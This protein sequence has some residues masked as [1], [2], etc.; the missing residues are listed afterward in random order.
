MHTET[1]FHADGEVR[2]VKPATTELEPGQGENY[3][4]IDILLAPEE[5]G[6]ETES[7]PF[8]IVEVGRHDDQWWLRLDQNL[9]YL[10]RMGEDQ[11]DTRLR[12]CDAPHFGRFDD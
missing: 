3:G 1:N 8:A 9:K 5:K 10:A 11:D 2:L 4:R 7:T 12:F 6:S